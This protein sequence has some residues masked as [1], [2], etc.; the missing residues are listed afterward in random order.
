MTKHNNHRHLVEIGRSLAIV[1]V[2]AAALGN[3]TEPGGKSIHWPT[4]SAKACFM[5]AGNIIT[6]INKGRR[7]TPMSGLLM[8]LITSIYA[9]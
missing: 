8:S 6:S 4:F 1:G 9:F 7:A 5:V 2:R 3:C